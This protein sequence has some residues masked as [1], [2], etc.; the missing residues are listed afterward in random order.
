MPNGEAA[1][2]SQAGGKGCQ[3]RTSRLLRPVSWLPAQFGSWTQSSHLLGETYKQL[4]T[5]SWL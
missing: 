2:F 4:S 1:R 3:G 5:F